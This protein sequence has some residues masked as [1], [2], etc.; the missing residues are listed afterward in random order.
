MVFFLC[1][2]RTRWH[3]LC[4]Q[5]PDNHEVNF[6][7]DYCVNSTSIT[8]RPTADEF[9]PCEDIMTTVP[10]RVLIWII[11]VLALLGNTAVLLVLLGKGRDN[12][13]K[14]NF[15]LSS[16][17]CYFLRS[18]FISVLLLSWPTFTFSHHLSCV[19]QFLSFLLCFPCFCSFF[20]SIPLY[21]FPSFLPSFSSL[22]L[23]WLLYLLLL[24]L[25]LPK[26][27]ITRIWHDSE[28]KGYSFS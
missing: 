4:S 7:K 17:P 12:H 23:S 16:F 9:N 3:P 1:C 8:C 28:M 24:P 25:L 13:R 5:I 15:L 14:V 10:L 19:Y 21:L 20:H 27:A 22:L 2:D 18:F 11:A 26:T 6:R